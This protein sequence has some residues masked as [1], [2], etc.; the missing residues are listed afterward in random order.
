[1]SRIVNIRGTSGSGKTTLVRHFLDECSS[2]T[3]LFGLF[4]KGKPEAMECVY[5]GQTVYLLGS[6]RNTCGGCDSI[7]KQDYVHQLVQD[8]SI[9]GHVLFEGL[10]ISHIYGRYAEAARSDLASW[11]F[12][13]LDT[14]FDT[15]ME[16]IR[17]RRIEAG[18]DPELKESVYRNARRTWE[19]TYRIR[20]KLTADGIT[21]YNLPMANR[22]PEFLNIMHAILGTGEG[23][24]SLLI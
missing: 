23:D 5:H 7:P 9:A 17:Q 24:D 21:W 2:T 13:M 6:Y 12:L 22:T 4:G 3:E 15:C 10:M 11:V 19:T 1:M 16:H 8:Y 20:E 14:P 18:K